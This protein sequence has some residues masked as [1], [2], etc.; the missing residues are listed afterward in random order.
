MAGRDDAS[1]FTLVP[2]LLMVVCY[3]IMII[4]A[5]WLL[6]KKKIRKAHHFMLLN[7]SLPFLGS[8]IES[9]E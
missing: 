2:L 1:I 7:L 4:Y 9:F 6:Y 3:A 5:E 8:I